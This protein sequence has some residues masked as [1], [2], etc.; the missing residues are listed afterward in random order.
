MSEPWMQALSAVIGENRWAPAR[1]AGLRRAERELYGSVVGSF[2]D[3]GAPD[4]WLQG[5]RAELGRLVDR[6]LLGLDHDGVV[7]VAYPFSARPTRHRVRTDD[8]RRYWA[9]C[10]IDAFGIAFLVRRRAEIDAREPG[11]ERP[12]TV[13]VDPLA[14]TVS[15]HPPDATVVAA[16]R[17]DGCVADC[18]CPHINL[19]G[20]RADAE[21]HLAAP[22]LRGVLLTVAEAAAAGR[23]LFGGLHDLIASASSA[24]L[25][26][27]GPGRDRSVPSA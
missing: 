22:E 13:I 23:A 25:G 17:G 4:A 6:D 20:S 21:R 5:R 2:L 24:Q 14:G 9:M 11:S 7:V 1:V 3:G 18:A 10:A 19:F 15:S 12:V 8:G 27:V 26:A 16:R